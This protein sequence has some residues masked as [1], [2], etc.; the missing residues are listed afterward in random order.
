MIGKGQGTDWSGIVREMQNY[1]ESQ[2]KVGNCTSLG[3]K[4]A[5]THT[6]T[7]LTALCPGLPGWAG[8]REKPIWIL[9]EQETVRGTGISWTVCK[10]APR[11]RQ[12]T[13]PAPH[14]SVFTGRMP[15]PPPN[16]QRQSSEGK[17]VPVI[18]RITDILRN[19]KQYMKCMNEKKVKNPGKNSLSTVKST[20]R[21][22]FCWCSL[23]AFGTEMCG[24]IGQWLVCDW[25][26][27]SGFY[28]E[29][30]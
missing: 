10:S 27:K 9:L 23:C 21:G 8:T 15:F 18:E 24:N 2:G 26:E 25:L 22:N 3:R 7:H 5:S 4:C 29:E 17:N 19:F 1:L 6:H 12:I 13:T 28:L 11:S 30:L 20:C 16:Q 14:H